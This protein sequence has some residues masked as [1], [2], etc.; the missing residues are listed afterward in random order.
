MCRYLL[1]PPCNGKFADRSGAYSPTKSERGAGR[2]SLA[3]LAARRLSSEDSEQDRFRLFLFFP[4]DHSRVQ[5]RPLPGQKRGD[6]V[7]ANYIDGFQRARAYIGT[8]GP[9]PATFDSFWRMVWE[10]R[11]STIVALPHSERRSK[12][13]QG[14]PIKLYAAVGRG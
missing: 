6:Y 1:R 14:V 3:L 5:L 7:N 13:S 9:M 2:G 12:A 8:Q 4:D 10:Q 11:S